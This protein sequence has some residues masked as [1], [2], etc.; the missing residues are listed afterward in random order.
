MKAIL[1][2][3][4]MAI[5]V[6]A[7]ALECPDESLNL[8]YDDGQ[9]NYSFEFS[10]DNGIKTRVISMALDTSDEQIIEL[11]TGKKCISHSDIII[12]R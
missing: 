2:L 6:P 9:G 4:A 11:A 8:L 3:L 5:A 1:I 10:C 12:C 7:M